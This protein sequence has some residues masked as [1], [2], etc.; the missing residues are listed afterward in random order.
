[1]H[2]FYL[3]QDAVHGSEARIR[4]QEARHLSKVLRLGP[5]DRVE[6]ADGNGR[7]F[8]AEI[9][10]VSPR[11]AVVCLKGERLGERESPLHITVAQ[12]LIKEARMDELIRPLTELG[13]A[14][15]LPFTATR[16]VPVPDPARV[17]SRLQRWERIAQEAIKQ[18]GRT[19]IPEILAPVSFDEVLSLSRTCDR[20]I[21]FWEKSSLSVTLS[22]GN[23]PSPCRVML[24]IGPEGGLSD[25]E[26]LK[27]ET[28]GFE[29]FSLGPRILRAETATLAA[30]VLVQHLFGDL[31]P[32][33][34]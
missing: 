30:A 10:A 5:G 32:N 27:A 9:T 13:I 6:V 14:R 26:V 16:S 33:S 19:R 24:L 4:G 31:G 34:P 2:R 20:R 11:E 7:V 17:A 29:A 3:T 25:P 23:G 21:V 18:C 1:M 28:H 12:A 8:E 15:W 22:R